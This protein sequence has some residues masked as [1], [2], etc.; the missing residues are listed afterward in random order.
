M[1]KTINY[2]K[3]G[4]DYNV[5]VTY[6]AIHNIIY[7]YHDNAFYVSAPKFTS[8]KL[9]LTSLDKFYFRL[10]KPRPV[11]DNPIKDDSIIILG[12]SFVRQNSEVIGLFSYKNED[13]FTIQLK[14]YARR[15]FTNELLK[16]EE[17]MGIK[18][19]YQLKIR[20]MKTR[21]GSNSKLTHSISLQLSLIHYSL[22]IIDSVI[23]HELAH[24]FYFD[25]SQRFYNVVYKYCPNYDLLHKKLRKGEFQ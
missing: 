4:I 5:I 21:F 19:H 11:K 3:N 16:Y 15:I 13:Q 14:K 24:Y 1:N 6:K 2:T 20:D 25:H 22:D 10:T 23:V 7:R 17:L 8:Q 18:D 12:Q 9:I